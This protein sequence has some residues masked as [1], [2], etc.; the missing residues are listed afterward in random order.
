MGMSIL[1]Q[2]NYECCCMDTSKIG[3]SCFMNVPSRILLDNC[4]SKRIECI[5]EDVVNEGL[6]GSL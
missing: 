1:M 6:Y 4:G 3:F 2:S 5:A